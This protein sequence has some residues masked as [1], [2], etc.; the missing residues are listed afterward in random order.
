MAEVY[1]HC[2][3][4]EHVFIDR[5][6]A[7]VDL[8]EAFVHAERLVRTMVMTPNTDLSMHWGHSRLDCLSCHR[9]S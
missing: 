2:S 6:G 5:R 8:S 7:A 4:A 3:D 1:F 9:R